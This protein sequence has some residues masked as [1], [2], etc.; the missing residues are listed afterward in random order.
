MSSERSALL[1]SSTEPVAISVGS[2]AGDAISLG[3][4]LPEATT[5]V[6]PCAQ[7]FSSPRFNGSI[8]GG[9]G[10]PEFSARFTTLTLESAALASLTACSPASTRDMDVE[11]SGIAT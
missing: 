9:N 3:P 10:L 1:F 5:T 11:P 7:R 6:I 4:S 8:H 2:E